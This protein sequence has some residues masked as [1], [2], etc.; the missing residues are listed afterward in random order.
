VD[1]ASFLPPPQ[2]STD[3]HFREVAVSWI[4][5]RV[6]RDL[7]ELTR[8]LTSHAVEVEEQLH[9]MDRVVAFNAELALTELELLADATVPEA[10]IV[11]LREMLLGAPERGRGRMNRLTEASQ[12]WAPEALT[13]VRSAVLDALEDLRGHVVDGTVAE[14]Q[15]LLHEGRVGR[16]LGA[17]YWPGMLG[18]LW[19][20][21]AGVARRSLGDERIQSLRLGLGLRVEAE[22]V[23]LQDALAAPASA[24]A[25]PV[26]YR[27]LFSERVMQ[28]GDLLIGRDVEAARVERV[29][30]DGPLHVAAIVGVKGTGTTALGV[31]VARSWEGPIRK[32]DLSAPVDASQVEQWFHEVPPG[33]LTVLS[34]LRWLHTSQAGG[35][36]PLRRLAALWVQHGQ[37]QAWVLTADADVWHQA[38]RLAPLDHA[39]ALTMRLD[40]L[41]LADLTRAILARHQMS[42]YDLYFDPADDLLWQ[43]WHLLLRNQETGAREREAWFRTLHHASGGVMHDALGL[44]MASI[45]RVDVERGCIHMGPVPWPPVARIAAMGD[46]VLLTLVQLNRQGWLDADQLATLFRIDLVA[47]QAQLGHLAHLGLLVH[48]ADGRFVAARHLRTAIRGALRSRGWM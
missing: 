6:T 44:W 3:V 25:L 35:L 24:A 29:L 13:G 40:P 7:A 8:S 16:A 21:L 43:L 32:L 23:V 34:G 18:E 37:T 36:A 4:E 48:E 41:N 31:A 45:R 27:R 10:S 12:V 5:S 39:V 42:G 20:Q 26:V 11:L 46:V 1:V 15:L 17:E 47:A 2:A 28:S 30:R 22:G 33:T 9:Q 19:T 38:S 14:L